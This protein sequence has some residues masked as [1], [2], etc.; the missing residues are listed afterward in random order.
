M[1]ICSENAFTETSRMMFDYILRHHGPAK[2]THEINHHILSVDRPAIHP[3]P[4]GYFSPLHIPGR[5]ISRLGSHFPRGSWWNGTN[6][7]AHPLPLLV[8]ASWPAAVQAW[9]WAGGCVGGTEHPC[10]GGWRK[11]LVNV[12]A[13]TTPK[14]FVPGCIPESS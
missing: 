2:M 1:L 4:R 9:A 5:I 3:R 7:H 12:V 8:K 11:S 6:H 13:P 14:I 10:N